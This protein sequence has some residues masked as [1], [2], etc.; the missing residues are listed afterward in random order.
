VCELVES[1]KEVIEE[2]NELELDRDA[3][4]VVQV[5][6]HNAGMVDNIKTI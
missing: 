1:R 6:D 3:A 4:S 2:L 5:R